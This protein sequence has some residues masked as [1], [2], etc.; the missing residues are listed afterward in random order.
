MQVAFNNL[1]IDQDR[2][3][4]LSLVKVVH[5]Y[6]LEHQDKKGQKLRN[7]FVDTPFEKL[8]LIFSYQE[9]Y[10]FHNMLQTVSLLLQAEDRN[11][12]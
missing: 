3:E 5:S 8:R 6:W 12:N 4:F 9:L 10:D 7:I 11:E 2:F 1:T